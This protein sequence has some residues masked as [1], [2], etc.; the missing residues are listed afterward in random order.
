LQEDQR[1]LKQLCR[2]AIFAH[3][4]ASQSQQPSVINLTMRKVANDEQLFRQ[5]LSEGKVGFHVRTWEDFAACASSRWSKHP[6]C[7]VIWQTKQ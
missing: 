6:F 3:W 4:L 2:N 7:V 5:H 1:I